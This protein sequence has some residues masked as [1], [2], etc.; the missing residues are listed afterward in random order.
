MRF[1]RGNLWCDGTGDGYTDL[2]P[3][4]RSWG[5]EMNQYETTP[6]ED[7]DRT[8]GHLSHY[9]CCNSA[10]V[11]IRQRYEDGTAS[12]IL[13]TN[14][15]ATTPNSNFAVN[16]QK[17]F[18]RVLSGGAEGEWD[19]L[20]NRRDGNRFAKATVHGMNGLLIF[21]DGY[22]L[23]S[24]YS[25]AGGTGMTKVNASADE[26]YPSSSEIPAET[27]SEMEANGVVFLP[28]AGFCYD[29]K[30][31]VFSISYDLSYVGDV[32]YQGIY[33]SSSMS[34]VGYL[35]YCLLFDSYNVNPFYEVLQFYASAVRLVTDVN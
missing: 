11:S 19:Y 23:P 4:I 1:S 5:F 33:W 14:A 27:W 9:V 8:I 21:P 12:N 26:Y 15:D 13:F 2:E 10:E 25:S 34:P 35:T 17:G 16:G 20:L 3:K 18:W 28:A 30:G 22:S 32:G 31:G 7:G 24:G 29:Q 6:S